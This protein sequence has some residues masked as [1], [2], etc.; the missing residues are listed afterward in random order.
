VAHLQAA[1]VRIKLWH[2]FDNSA[3]G[4]RILPPG[5]WAITGGIDVGLR[6]LVMAAFFGFRDLHVFGL[7]GSA[8]APEAPR[9]AGAHPTGDKRYG[10]VTAE[11]RDFYTTP[12]MLEAARG[13]CHELDMMP[14]V[15][16]T[17]YGD[18]LIPWM[19]RHR[20]PAPGG[21]DL[22]GF[23]RERCFTPEY[24]AISRQLHESNVAYG[25]GG[26]KHTD[27]V[28][29]LCKALGSKNV[30]DYGCGKGRLAASLPFGICE[31]DPAIPGKDAAPRPADL[32][33]CTDVLEHVEPECLDGVLADL[34]R[35]VRQ[36]GYLTIHTGPAKKTLPDGRNTHLI[37]EG[38]AWWTAALE[39]YFWVAKVVSEGPKLK[40][41][42]APRWARPRAAGRVSVPAEVAEAMLQEATV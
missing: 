40:V 10:V 18:G 4:K 41:I 27:Q 1:G 39:R 17:F 42:I 30:L 25:V 22:V 16:A 3:E 33:V 6:S 32:V 35:C 15:T 21:R 14:T 31:Y 7:D 26:E 34:A 2:I 38:R 28:L 29:K 37:Q 19:V 5:E 23:Q 12:A 9:H 11:G 24:I 13:V 36:V 8:P 20:T